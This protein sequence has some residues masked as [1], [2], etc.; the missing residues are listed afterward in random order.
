MPGPTTNVCPPGNSGLAPQGIKCAKDLV[1]HFFTFKTA[2]DL[3]TAPFSVPAGY[4][5]IITGVNLGATK[6]SLSYSVVGDE[7]CEERYFV[8]VTN[9]CAWELS[10]AKAQQPIKLQGVYRLC[11]DAANADAKVKIEVVQLGSSACCA[12]EYLCVGGTNAGGGAQTLTG[13]GI[14]TVT[15]TATGFNVNVP[16]PVIPPEVHVT[17]ATIAV[18]GTPLVGTGPEAQAFNIVLP[19]P[20]TVSGTGIATVTT[21]AT[22]YNVNVPAPVIPPEVHVTPAKINVNGAPLV[23]TGPEAQE[24]SLTIPA[25]TVVTGTGIATVTPTAA[26]YEV[27]V[28]APVIPPEVHVTP[29]KISVNGTPVV[30]TGPEAQDFALVIP[31]VDCAAIKTVHA[32]DGTIT[33]LIGTDA[34]DAC[35][36]EDIVDLTCPTTAVVQL[37]SEGTFIAMACVAGEPTLTNFKLPTSA[38]A[39]VETPLV[40][41]MNGAAAGVTQ[42][43]TANHTVDL[44]IPASPNFAMTVKDAA[45]T[46]ITATAVVA[47]GTQGHGPTLNLPCPPVCK[48][49]TNCVSMANTATVPTTIA[50]GSMAPVTATRIG[51]Y[52]PPNPLDGQ[53]A[54]TG[55][56]DMSNMV[57][58]GSVSGGAGDLIIVS[59]MSTNTYPQPSNFYYNGFGIDLLGISGMTGLTFVE[60]TEAVGQIVQPWGDDGHRQTKFAAYATGAYSGTPKL[61]AVYTNGNA[62][63]NSQ[64]ADFGKVVFAVDKYTG[65]TGLPT[66][67]YTGG[68]DNANTY[69]ATAPTF[70]AGNAYIM[71]A[72]SNHSELPSGNLITDSAWTNL[73]DVNYAPTGQGPGTCNG[74]ITTGFSLI[75]AA[76]TVN[77]A[78]FGPN[79]DPANITQQQSLS[80]LQAPRAVGGPSWQSVTAGSLTGTVTAPNCVCESNYKVE[81]KYTP[82]LI[83]VT[84]P[85]NST[86][87]FRAKVGAAQTVA[88]QQTINIGASGSAVITVPENT[89]LVNA[90]VGDGVVSTYD[91]IYE[92]FPSS[93]PTNGSVVVNFG[94]AK[95]CLTATPA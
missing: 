4:T 85:A 11:A 22:G 56:F 69:L 38:P 23:G 87:D 3:C 70:T 83:S 77:V 68:T 32:T 46:D 53:F 41:T 62:A 64:I 6:V 43:G 93:M 66:T 17:P 12:I 1:K 20:V 80:I 47:G 67:V 21:T 39:A 28:P 37:P 74:G 9:P 16:A 36:G 25:A 31:P 91:V 15:T 59:V 13:T 82:G 14:A 73:G 86:I 89:S 42:S 35:V 34:A 8:P 88:W 50:G 7:R 49:V 26:G 51:S 2:A 44:T 75:D 33:R 54:A 76:P 29:A 65:F 60:L 19:A 5:A 79:N 27:N 10:T 63:Q 52:Q 95:V 78:V 90:G 58:S 72:A 40:V 71:T 48:P 84:A 18:N 57:A 81:A 24:F 45:G 30:G 61:D 94:P 92:W 55:A